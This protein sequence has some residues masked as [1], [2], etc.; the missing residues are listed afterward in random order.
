MSNIINGLR[1]EV[2]NGNF[3]KAMRQFKKK[4]QNAGI[5]QEVRDRQYYE[6]PSEKR[7]RTMNAAKRRAQ[8]REPFEF[9]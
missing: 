5:I 1:V 9:S 6:T 4:V 2:Y 3:E 8:K 7:Q